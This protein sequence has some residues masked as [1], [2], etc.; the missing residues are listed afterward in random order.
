[1][2]SFFC[3]NIRIVNPCI[4]ESVSG[5][6]APVAHVTKMHVQVLLDAQPQIVLE[7]ALS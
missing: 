5:Q 4:P 3:Y 2:L 1:M 6:R 7:S